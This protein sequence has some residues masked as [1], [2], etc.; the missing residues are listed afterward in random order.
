MDEAGL[1]NRLYRPYAR[2][3]R[4]VKVH[5]HLPG[6][7]RERISM[8]GGWVLNRFIAPMSFQGGCNNQVLNAWLQEILLPQLKPGTTIIM[9]NAA[10]HKSSK[11]KEIIEES[12]C[13]LK[14]LPTYSP[15]LNPVEHCWHSIKSALKPLIQEP[16]ENLHQLVDNALL[17]LFQKGN[18]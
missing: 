8:I 16:Y 18:S 13:F 3:L 17:E 12:G 4:G 10:F 11:T 1:D 6:K 15:D 2:S 9:D 5:A 7:K 14:F